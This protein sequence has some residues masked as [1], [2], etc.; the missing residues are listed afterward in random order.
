M[1]LSIFK[2]H[3]EAGKPFFVWFNT[4]WMH[5]RVHIPDRIQRQSGRWQSEYYD[6]MIEHDRRI[7][8]LLDLLDEIGIADD[9]IVIYSTDNGPYMNTWPDAAMTP[10]C[11]EKN[12]CWEGAFRVPEIVRW[13]SK[14]PEGTISNF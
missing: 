2:R 4:T 10:F 6:A 13:P 8:M 9:T 12:S 11:N 3:H 1:Q 7:G 14:I 5:F